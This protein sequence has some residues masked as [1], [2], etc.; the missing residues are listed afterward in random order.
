M[1]QYIEYVADRLAVSLGYTKIYKSSNPFGFMDTIGM[2]QKTNFHESRATE[3]KSAHLE[4]TTE[5][6][7][8]IMENDDF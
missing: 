3:Y 8:K 2:M 4:Y 5:S 1:N 6:T 7:F